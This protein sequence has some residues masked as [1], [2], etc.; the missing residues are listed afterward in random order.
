V[1]TG[2]LNLVCQEHEQEA[3]LADIT[4]AS[5]APESVAELPTNNP[6]HPAALGDIDVDHAAGAGEESMPADGDCPS[7]LSADAAPAA[8]STQPR[9]RG[10]AKPREYALPDMLGA[11]VEY[12]E[13]GALD[14]DEEAGELPTNL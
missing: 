3:A 9:V 5:E 1:P 11:I 7:T 2:H 12:E 10:R 6:V 4:P 14:S 8:R 13:Y